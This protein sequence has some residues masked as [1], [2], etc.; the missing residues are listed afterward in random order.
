IFIFYYRIFNCHRGLYMELDEKSIISEGKQIEKEI[1][2]EPEP[3]ENIKEELYQ[4]IIQ[5]LKD[6]GI[7]HD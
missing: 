2:D 4:R 5:E 3:P 7:Y 1:E 6:R